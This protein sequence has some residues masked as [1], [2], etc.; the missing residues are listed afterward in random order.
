M[1]ESP[2]F[3]SEAARKF[4][5]SIVSWRTMFEYQAGHERVMEANE[6]L[7]IKLVHRLPLLDLST[8]EHMSGPPPLPPRP[9]GP[10]PI[11]PRP[12]YSNGQDCAAS[13]G[14]PSFPPIVRGDLLADGTKTQAGVLKRGIK[15]QASGILERGAK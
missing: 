15:W 9:E 14:P 8:Y 13:D 4:L 7:I 2:G 12:D 3:L 5:D 6:I 1:I 11:P 10:P